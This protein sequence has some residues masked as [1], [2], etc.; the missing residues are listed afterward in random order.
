MSIEFSKDQLVKAFPDQSGNSSKYL[1]T[2][3][4]EPSWED[5]PQQPAV[6]LSRL[7][8]DG[9]TSLSQ[10]W[11]RAMS[12]ISTPS[13]QYYQ[14]NHIVLGKY[15][16][17]ASGVWP[18]NTP[19][20]IPSDFTVSGGKVEWTNTNETV[21]YKRQR[22]MF[23][24]IGATGANPVTINADIAEGDNT[25]TI[26]STT[27][28]EVGGYV[29]ISC[30]TVADQTTGMFPIIY[31]FAKITS[32][33]GNVIGI[34]TKFA[35]PVDRATILATD[36]TATFTVTYY[37]EEAVPKN[38]R[39]YDI[40]I[41]DSGIAV[42]HA[43]RATNNPVQ[44]DYVIGPFY[45]QYV[46]NIEVRK[47]R[48]ESLTCP[49]VQIREYVDCAVYDL[50]S[51]YP[52]AISAGEGYTVTMS[53]GSRG[54]QYRCGG[55]ETR[56][57][58][59]FTSTWD[60][61]A[62]DCWD[63]TPASGDAKTDRVSFLVHARYDAD[64]KWVRCNGLRL[65]TGAGFGF[66]MWVNNMTFDS[67][68]LRAL[69]GR[70]A[71]GQ[72][73]FKGGSIESLGTY[74]GDQI[75][76]DGTYVIAESGYFRLENRPN[77][78][79]LSTNGVELRGKTRLR[80]EN[81]EYFNSFSVGKDV[82]LRNGSATTTLI[83][84][85]LDVK[86][87]IIDGY[88]ER[89]RFIIK[90]APERITIG[91]NAHFWTDLHTTSGGFV[92][93]KDLTVGK[94]DFT[95]H[96]KF[97]TTYVGTDFSRPFVIEK[98]LGVDFTVNCNITGTRFVGTWDEVS[99]IVS[100]GLTVRGTISGNIYEGATAINLM[101]APTFGVRQIWP[102]SV[103]VHNNWHETEDNNWD[104]TDHV[105]TQGITETLTANEVKSFLLTK[106]DWF[107]LP[108]VYHLTGALTGTDATNVAVLTVWDNGTNL[109]CKLWNTTSSSVNVSD[110]IV[111]KATIS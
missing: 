70:G 18:H 71:V 37:A 27:G 102:S 8:Q 1:T 97:E 2:D 99:R 89:R 51:Q 79:P 109:A 75:I 30:D 52:R 60:G 86:N 57:V 12:E 59:D 50:Y 46:D 32:I 22:G 90:G 101:D 62:E 87:I 106:P 24:A 72:T 6:L 20:Q 103:K 111:L 98:D 38:I 29:Y 28:M 68:N 61:L 96:G 49:L 19:V 58:C 66:G 85:I 45:F 14:T 39:V 81:V 41:L 33:S 104:N 88:V 63:D 34:N 94:I 11:N 15:P 80:L 105:W 13:S 47:C 3:G 36:S 67:C 25:L 64:I 92:N 84:E 35:W 77:Y 55:Y 54:R 100:P 5:I 53:R 108:E 40:D 95:C 44:P 82:E 10:A 23:E 31:T 48:G 91:E 9:D 26:A 69:N 76:I 110:T 4:T 73:I 78:V 93:I 65:S 74:I 56:H 7:Y 43:P 16:G 17:D 83:S 107:S 21:V 42:S